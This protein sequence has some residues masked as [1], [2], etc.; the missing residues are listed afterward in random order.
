MIIKNAKI[1]E[2]IKNIV[3]ENGIITDITEEVC[4]GEE[5]DANGNSV[6]PGLID[7][8]THGIMGYDTMDADFEPMCENYAK[9]GTTSFLPTNQSR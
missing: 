6:I 3:I 8:H 7:V 5:I 2:E 4:S 9:F 1:G